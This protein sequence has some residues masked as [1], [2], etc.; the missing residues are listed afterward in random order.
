MGI[1]NFML[2]SVGMTYIMP[3]TNNKSLQQ[4]TLLFWGSTNVVQNGHCSMS[5]YQPGHVSATRLQH[6]T[7][8]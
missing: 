4:V 3:E 8:I 7:M 6:Y 5:W 2:F 1:Q